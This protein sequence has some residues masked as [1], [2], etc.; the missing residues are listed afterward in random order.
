MSVCSTHM[1]TRDGACC[2]EMS[3]D[4]SDIYPLPVLHSQ[5]L[6][7]V[8][9]HM[10]LRYIHVHTHNLQDKTT[11]PCEF[12]NNASTSVEVWVQTT[13]NMGSS[14][15]RNGQ[16]RCIINIPLFFFVDNLPPCRLLTLWTAADPAGAD[17]IHTPRAGHIVGTSV[18][19]YAH[20]NVISVCM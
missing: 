2:T 3:L 4:S 5:S 8:H 11:G 17:V 6:C 14:A 15:A 1:L 16:N 9:I 20:V 12:I 18:C 19:M 10:Y 13:A 7:L